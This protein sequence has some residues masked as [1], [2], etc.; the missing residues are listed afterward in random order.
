[1]VLKEKYRLVPADLALLGLQLV[2]SVHAQHGLH[3]K[4]LQDVIDDFQC[5]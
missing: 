1:M 3:R 4:F 5:L 2:D